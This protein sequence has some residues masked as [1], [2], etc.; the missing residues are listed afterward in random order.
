MQDLSERLASSAVPA[1][2]LARRFPPERALATGSHVGGLPALPAGVAWPRMPGNGKPVHFLAQIRCEDLPAID[3]DMPSTG[4]LFFFARIDDEQIYDEGDPL[5]DGRVIYSP[6]GPGTV[7]LPPSD[8]PEI[9]GNYGRYCVYHFDGEPGWRIFPSSPVRF[10]SIHAW[11][12]HDQLE[13]RESIDYTTYLNAVRESVVDSL[14]HAFGLDLDRPIVP[15][16]VPLRG[17]LARDDDMLPPDVDGSRFPQIWRLIDSLARNLLQG[18]LKHLLT[19][20][21]SEA[22]AW[23]YKANSAGLAEVV[24]PQ[25]VAAFRGWLN[26]LVD[27]QSGKRSY[28]AYWVYRS[29]QE[30]VAFLGCY[31]DAIKYIP[32]Q[33]FRSMTEDNAPVFR[34]IQPHRGVVAFAKYHQMLG[35][36]PQLH[37]RHRK[38]SNK[39]RVMLLRLFSDDGSAFMFCDDGEISFLIDRADL[40]VR[41]FDKVYVTAE[42]H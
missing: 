11:P 21:E 22:H 14:A 41:H 12:E 9:G 7:T 27:G 40:K 5:D 1:I 3:P 18:T 38:S 36:P 20:R 10:G 33:Y 2:A 25:D 34:Q 13:D 17:P 15:T 4:M 42:G 6:S 16:I 28:I 29:M 24:P 19:G 8:L 30:L 37:G 23:I 32:T 26:E 35:Y 39:T 31:P